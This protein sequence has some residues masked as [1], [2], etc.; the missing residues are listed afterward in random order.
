[1]LQSGIDAA[2]AFAKGDPPALVQRV[3]PALPSTSKPLSK[4]SDVHKAR[5]WLMKGHAEWPEGQL[6][7]PL[8]EDVKALREVGFTTIS[9]ESVEALRKEIAPHLVRK[10]GRPTSQ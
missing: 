6:L 4:S 5:L 8:A 3:E 7:P 1:M 2:L 10:R 9:R